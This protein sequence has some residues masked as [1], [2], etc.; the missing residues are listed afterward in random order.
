MEDA[1]AELEEYER[2]MEEEYLSTVV[3]EEFGF[4]GGG[5]AGPECGQVSVLC[6]ICKRKWL[7]SYG[8]HIRCSCG[9]QVPL[10][11]RYVL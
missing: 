4:S 10:E 9:F 6:P 11:V 1:Y 8:D 7:Q 2:R 5:V 3:D